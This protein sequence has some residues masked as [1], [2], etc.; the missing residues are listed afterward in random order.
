MRGTGSQLLA[1]IYDIVSK[2]YNYN[3]VTVGEGGWNIPK[4]M[5]HH[6]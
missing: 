5:W 2:T 3:C 1:N 4:Y 6:L